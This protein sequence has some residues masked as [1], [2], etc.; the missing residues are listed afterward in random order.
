MKAL[1]TFCPD[2]FGMSVSRIGCQVFIYFVVVSL[3]ATNYGAAVGEKGQ[4][5]NIYS[6]V[7]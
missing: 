6:E 5:N 7:A 1:G 4:V 3:A 2:I